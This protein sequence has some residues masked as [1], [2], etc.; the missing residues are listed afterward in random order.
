MT[1]IIEGFGPQRD[2]QTYAVI[3]AAMAVHRE[4][5]CGFLEPVYQ[6][7]LAIELALRAIPFRK[8]VLLP[9]SYRG[10]LLHTAYRVDFVCFD[11]LL[12]ELKALQRLS[13]VEK[14][15]LLNYLKASNLPKALL[16]NFGA[17]RL[18]YRRY[19]GAAHFSD[20]EEEAIHR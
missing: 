11:G 5:G 20:V 2:E 4:L 18:E 12:V 14:A 3:G 10:Q 15:Q 8:E 9:V 19:V 16:L 7:T 13:G 1:Q 6:E 17:V